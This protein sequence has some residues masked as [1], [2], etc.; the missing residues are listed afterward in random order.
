MPLPDPEAVCLT[1]ADP[2][3]LVRT[4]PDPDPEPEFVRED[5]AVAEELLEALL[6][7]DSEPVIDT[8]GELDP[9]RELDTV[10]EDER[11]DWGD[12]V[13]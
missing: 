10:P 11:E 2:E 12:C 6:V 3:L 13:A 7:A 5:V 1:V 8:N 9:E 4:V